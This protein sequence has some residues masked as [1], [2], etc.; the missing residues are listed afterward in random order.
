MAGK[1]QPSAEE[2][3]QGQPEPQLAP[4]IQIT[5]E[6]LKKMLG[7][8]PAT[9]PVSDDGQKLDEIRPGGYF[10]VNSQAVNAFGKPI[11]E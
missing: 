9:E 5:A 2:P 8:K 3:K 11:K 10:I 4:T 7:G 1:T 6:E